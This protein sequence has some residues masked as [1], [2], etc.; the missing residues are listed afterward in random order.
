M[1]SPFCQGH[2]HLFRQPTT[3]S[4]R[5]LAPTSV[6]RAE[7]PCRKPTKAWRSLLSLP[8]LAT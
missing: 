7:S 8:A 5:G 4:S 6:A 2:E 3:A 1:V